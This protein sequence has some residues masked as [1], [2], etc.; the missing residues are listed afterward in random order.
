MTEKNESN[1]IN[2]INQ[3]FQSFLNYP[4]FG[5]ICIIIISF[6]L[7]FYYFDP[8]IPPTLDALE[9]FFYAID[10][11]I[12][13]HLPSFYSSYHKL[14]RKL[15]LKGRTSS[16][17]LL[18]FRLLLLYTFGSG[19][20]HQIVRFLMIF[21]QSSMERMISKWVGWIRMSSRDNATYNQRKYNQVLPIIRIIY[22]Y[23]IGR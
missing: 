21:S 7:R 3:F 22:G 14:D 17:T 6:L 16:C 20:S 23:D 19:M 8:E 18:I 12:I 1:I 5:L 15:S 4:L 9:Y 2:P 10:T 11:S 13:G